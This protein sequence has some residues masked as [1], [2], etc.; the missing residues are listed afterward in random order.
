MKLCNLDNWFTSTT[1]TGRVIDVSNSNVSGYNVIADND[2][3]Q[4]IGTAFAEG[5]AS[6]DA[7][8]TEMRMTL[9]YTQIF[10]TSCELS[11]TAIATRYRGYANEFET[12]LGNQTS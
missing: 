3:C 5:T 6:P 7:F 9:D 11:N 2:V 4:V 8:S 10:K 1:F 12:H